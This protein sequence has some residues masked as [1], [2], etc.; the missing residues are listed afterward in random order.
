MKLNL[1]FILYLLFQFAFYNVESQNL[2]LKINGKDSTQTKIIDSLGYQKTFKNYKSLK[3]HSLELISKLQNLGFIEIKTSEI[4]K[5]ESSKFES[6]F[7]LKQKFNTIYIYNYKSH[8]NEG[9]LTNII[10]DINSDYFSIPISKLES[11]LNHLNSILINKGSPF[12]TLQLRNIEKTKSNNI[13]AE[14]QLTIDKK[15]TINNIIIKGY[16]KFPKSYLRHFLKIKRNSLF[17]LDDLKDK[18]SR[19]TSIPFAE[20]LKAPEILFSKDSTTIYLYLKKIKSNSFDGF[21]GFGT[22]EDNNKLKFDGYLNLVLV[23]NLNYGESLKVNY[24][25][26]ELDQKTFNI[27]LN[28]PYIL[29]TP[30]G[31]NLELNIFKKDSSFTTAKQF[32]NIY[33]QINPSQKIHTGI[34]SIQSNNLLR[35]NTDN[36]KDYKSTFYS[37]KYE[38]IKNNPENRMFPTNFSLSLDLSLGH[39]KQESIKSS[40]SLGNLTLEKLF[41]LNSKSSFFSKIN[42]SI[43]LSDNYLNNELFRFGGINS[44]RGFEENS[45]EANTLGVLN[46]EYRHLLSQNLY[47]HSIIDVAYFENKNNSI[48]EKLFGFGFGFGLITQAGLLKF[49]YANGKSDD[50][51]F[52]L[53]NSKIHLSLTAKF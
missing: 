41:T 29:K 49:N 39:R 50:Q 53:S 42:S 27:D 4:R 22:N 17:S 36:L 12:A 5:T 15:R 45:I 24:K 11:T 34:Q 37:I 7:D 3:S 1:T 9:D 48:K 28:L 46:T 16:E 52:K 38:Y 2:Y 6:T 44:I 51:K 20:E 30:I 43:L 35:N 32:A 33:Y 25:S 18:S 8:F 40:Q 47:I 10:S 13:K 23:N 14:L 31:T 19:L 21:L 26:D